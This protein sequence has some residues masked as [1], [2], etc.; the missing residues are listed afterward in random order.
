VGEGRA[1]STRTC[2]RC[3]SL[4]LAAEGVELHLAGKTAGRSTLPTPK[5][6]QML[7]GAEGVELEVTADAVEEIARLAEELNTQVRGRGVEHRS[8][9]RSNA[10]PPLRAGPAGLRQAECT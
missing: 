6:Y 8:N 2:W 3:P 10:A 9:A 4:L 5:P 1:S 7:L